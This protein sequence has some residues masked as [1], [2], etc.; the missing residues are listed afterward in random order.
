MAGD[1]EG[2]AVLARDAG[3]RLLM[4]G[5]RL[6]AAESCTGGWIAKVMTDVAG[7]SRWFE[8][9]LVTYSNTAKTRLLGVDEALLERHGAVSEEVARA[10]ARGAVAGTADRVAVAVTGVAGPDGG[11]PDKPVGLVWLA[12]A[13]SAGRGASYRARFDGDRAAVRRQSVVAALQGLCTF[14][15]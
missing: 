14:L 1:D 4:R 12:W 6:I 3:Q 7:S 5:Q 11:T 13:D 2:L 10:M 9:G 8:H 15:G